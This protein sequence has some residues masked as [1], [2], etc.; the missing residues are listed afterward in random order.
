MVNTL[1][2]LFFLFITKD[3]VFMMAATQVFASVS[4][5]VTKLTDC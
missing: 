1:F 4:L 2:L 3:S 5:C